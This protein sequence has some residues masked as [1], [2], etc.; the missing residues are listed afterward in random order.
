MGVQ[1]DITRNVKAAA[2]RD[3]PSRHFGSTNKRHM[4]VILCTW[5]LFGIRVKSS[6]KAQEP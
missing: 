1:H 4:D 5:D 3:T 2:I 6:H